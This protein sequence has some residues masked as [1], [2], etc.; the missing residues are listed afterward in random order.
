MKSSKLVLLTL[1][2]VMC[3]GI[4]SASIA[5]YSTT[6]DIIKVYDNE[7]KKIGDEEYEI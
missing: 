3:I 1:A 7:G 6:T 4:A 5:T 2:L